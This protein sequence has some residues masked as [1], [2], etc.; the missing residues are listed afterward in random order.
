[1]KRNVIVLGMAILC[2]LLAEISSSNGVFFSDNFYIKDTK[3]DKSLM[4]D[5]SFGIRFRHRKQK[6]KKLKIYG[7]G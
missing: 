6:Y 3:L 7:E 4:I 1:M 5:S 2:N